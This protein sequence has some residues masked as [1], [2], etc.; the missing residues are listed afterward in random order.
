MTERVT[1]PE[2]ETMS[3]EQAAVYERFQ[4]NLTRALLLTKNSAGAHLA[5]GATFTVGLLSDLLRE[6]VVL[7][8][9]ALRDSDFERA[10]HYPLALKAG[11]DEDEI[12][13]IEKG[14]FDGMPADRAALV[15]YVDDCIQLH[16]AG[17]E[18]FWGAARALL[19]ERDR[20]GHASGRARR[21][22]RDVPG[23]PGDPAGREIRVLVP[24]HRTAELMPTAGPV[25][26]ARRH[27]R[28]R[29]ET[30]NTSG[31]VRPA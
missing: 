30:W 12:E 22:D 8:V 10:L 1:L 17:E 21:D 20:R 28:G 29:G 19:A 25:H 23:Q 2:V 9:A 11:L 18:A 13:A 4:S 31:W 5:L 15:R 27:R 6:V 7:R 3:P 24:A 14:R 16:K 26:R